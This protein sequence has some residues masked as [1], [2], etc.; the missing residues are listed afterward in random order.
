MSANGV[1][2]RSC[3]TVKGKILNQIV[4]G[5]RR[6]IGEKNEKLDFNP[7]NVSDKGCI[8]IAL[9][10]TFHYWFWY[11]DSPAS[12][13]ATFI[14]FI[15]TL[16]FDELSTMQRD[17]WVGLTLWI[18]RLR[19]ILH[20]GLKSFPSPCGFHR[21]SRLIYLTRIRRFGWVTMTRIIKCCS[22]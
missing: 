16:S 10:S 5:K 20:M 2:P 7:P 9:Y 13:R 22:L 17:S 4:C 11:F 3:E 12:F 18:C 14:F 19:N 8:D 6:F 21:V 15:S 1:Y